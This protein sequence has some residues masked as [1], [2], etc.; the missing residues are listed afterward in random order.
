MRLNLRM[1]VALLALLA[2]GSVALAAEPSYAAGTPAP[3][4]EGGYL[5][6]RGGLAV[7]D[8]V[9]KLLVAVLVA[10]GAVHLLRWWHNERPHSGAGDG[11]GGRRLRLDEVLSLGN[12]GRLYLVEVEGRRMLLAA[13]EGSLSQ[14]AE[15]AEERPEAS[16]YR[17]VRR[18]ADGGMD[19]LRVA[20]A[21]VSTRAVRADLVE[22]P[23]DWE[24]RRA[25]L[26]HELQE[27][28]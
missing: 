25:K 24:Q 26:L 14:V 18:R 10:W 19:E 6:A 2:L 13:R 15:L 22:E 16:V 27:Q 17:S 4:D 9:G 12:D 20:Q 5:P 28:G 3:A 11:S 7:F 8:V 23:G 21:P 1:L